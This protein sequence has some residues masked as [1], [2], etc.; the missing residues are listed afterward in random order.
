MKLSSITRVNPREQQLFAK[1]NN[2]TVARARDTVVRLFERQVA[3]TPE[4]DACHD[5]RGALSYAQLNARANQLAH[6][7]R[8][9]GVQTETRVALLSERSGEFLVGLLG[10]LKAG[11]CVVPLDPNYPAGYLSHITD[12]A[13]PQWLV[14]SPAQAALAQRFEVA[15]LRLDDP[16]LAAQSDADPAWEVAPEQLSHLMYTSGSTGRPKGVMVPH[17]QLINWLLAL[18]ERMPFGPDEM[19]AQKTSIAFAVSVKELLAGLLC[20]APLVFVDDDAARDMPA[21]VAMLERWQVTRVNLVPSHLQALLASLGDNAQALRALKYCTT[22][23]EPLTDTVRREMHVALPWVQL[24]NNFGCTELNDVTYSACAPL[25]EGPAQEVFAPIGKPIANTRVY[26]LDQ[27]LAQVPIG[28]AGELCVDSIG[29]ARGYWRKPDLTAERFV[30]HPFSERPGARLYRTGDLVRYLA[31]G[32]LEY[33]GREDFE[34]KLRGHRIDVRQVE[35]ALREDETVLQAVVAGWPQPGP[36]SQLLAY[37]VMRDGQSLQPEALRARLG[38]RLPQFMVPGLFVALDALPRLPNGKLDRKSLPAPDAIEAPAEAQAEPV[39]PTEVALHAIWL[40]LLAVPAS[41]L[42]VHSNFFAV[43]GHSLL[44]TRVISKVHSVFGVEMPLRAMF[45]HPTVA[46]MAKW[47]DEALL[48]GAA[49]AAPAIAPADRSASLP[50]SFAQQRL[51]FLDQYQPGSAFYNVPV[52]VRLTGELNLAALQQTMDRI[53]ARHESLRTAFAQ[54]DGQPVQRIAAVAELPIAVTDLSGLP[55]QEREDSALALARAA[56]RVP[57]TLSNAPLMRVALFRIDGGQHLCA[58]SMHHIVSDGWSMGILVDEVAQ[59]YSAFVAG[60]PDPLPPLPIQYADFVQ[61][62]RQWLSGELLQQRLSYWQQQLGGAPALLTLPTDRPRPLYQSNRG[63]SLRVSLSTELVAG[64]QALAQNRQSTL[65]MALTAAF[66]VLLSR[67]A[68]QDDICIGTPIANRNRL[69]TERLIGFFANTL[70][71]RTRVDSG[72][73]F[74]QLLQQVRGTTLDAYAHQDVPFEQLV[75]VLKPERHTSHSPLF[76]VMLMLQN[77]PQQAVSLHGL[78]MQEVVTEHATAKF[79]LT[80]NLSETERG[81]QGVFEYNTDL[82]DASTIE[83]MAGHFTRL[84]EAIVADPERRIRDLDMLDDA[85]RRQMLVEWNDT[86]RDYRSA[87][88]MPAL[89]EERAAASPESVALVYAE[90]QLTYGELNARAN[91]LAHHL[92]TLGVGPDV[93]VGLCVE[94]SLEMVVGLLAILKAGGAYVPLDP[95]YP[96]DRL[97]YMLED[98]APVVLLTQQ[99]LLVSV[100]SGGVPVF[101]LDADAAL[102]DAYAATNPVAVA[103]P[104]HLAYVIYTSGST[105]KPKGVALNRANLANFLHSMGEAPGM[106][107]DDVL[108]AVTSLSFDIAALE[109]FLPLANGAR[110]VVAGRETASNPQQLSELLVRSGATM[111]QATPSSWRMLVD[112]GW[113]QELQLKV[114]CGGEALPVGLM[115]DVLGHVDAIWNLYGPTETTIWSTLRRVSALDG[116]PVIGKPIANTQVYILDA[117]LNPVPAGVAGEL[118][119]AGEGLARGYLDRGDLTADKFIPRPVRGC[120]AP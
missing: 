34:I 8:A 84:L 54:E 78:T 97:A 46:D 39:T 9:L 94:R 41:R 93:L 87:S 26:V 5:D 20:G 83:R 58:F 103:L 70:V 11:A 65:F 73:R 101:C 102:L 4:R 16:D 112:H 13:Q 7:L 38:E 24:W 47:I 66:N 23:G 15:G 110:V 59:L 63:A 31:D 116:A 91:R 18:W 120:R 37:V 50:L 45:N 96:A 30:P 14:C 98:A 35:Q 56:L 40:E 90:E 32:S 17:W 89:F 119:I 48:A 60:R 44:A 51:W 105:G 2:T 69:E 62:Q 82:F 114:L 43:G 117:G 71:L 74:A 80:L 99:R 100:P 33:L 92:R 49:P 55:P 75:E 81:L 113:P 3:A 1:W 52:L 10:I 111:M 67:Y 106:N 25:A 95:A 42:G 72:E 36:A 64:L 88:M 12:D 53:V 21:F 109:L 77:V 85:E 57:Y 104:Q 68:G 29:I 115:R 6:R 79:D 22:A 118:H 28:V 107:S 19:V 61:W 108:V 76:Q 27:A 86:A